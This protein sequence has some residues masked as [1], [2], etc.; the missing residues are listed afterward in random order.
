MPG[1]Q[2][3]SRSPERL[4]GSRC[5]G[6]RRHFPATSPAVVVAGVSTL[7][8]VVGIGSLVLLWATV[9]GPRAVISGLVH[10]P[11]DLG[12]L[13]GQRTDS[14]DVVA[15]LV[16]LGWL[17]WLWMSI[18]TA[19]EV[20]AHIRGVHPIRLPGSAWLQ[21]AAGLAVGAMMAAVPAIRVGTIV[22]RMPD[23]THATAPGGHLVSA[24]TGPRSLVSRA[25]LAPYTTMAP[26]VASDV[27][28]QAGAVRPGFPE[29]VVAAMS[30]PGHDVDTGVGIVNEAIYVVQPGDTM[31]SI[32]A[33]QLG[34]PL[35]W[36]QIAA[37]NQ[38]RVQPGGQR[39]LD[40]NWILPGW[41]L[42]M[43]PTGPVG[44]AA[45][46]ATVHSS[47]VDTAVPSL[48]L[49][50]PQ[51][52][53]KH[54][55]QDQ[56]SHWQMSEIHSVNN[57]SLS[58]DP[59]PNSA[60]P[61]TVNPL[62]L[63]PASDA[64]G[65]NRAHSEDN[66]SDT[67]VTGHRGVDIGEGIVFSVLSAG[68]VMLVNRLRRVQQ[69]H[70]PT[71]LRI[72]LPSA[73]AAAV[74]GRL[75]HRANPQL[76]RQAG[77]VVSLLHRAAGEWGRT[78]PAVAGI[79]IGPGG[80]EVAVEEV[81]SKHRTLTEV[82]GGSG[83]IPPFVPGS[84]PG[85]WMA[86]TGFG[87][88]SSST[89][90]L[91]GESGRKSESDTPMEAPS[92]VV[93]LGDDHGDLILVDLGVLSTLALDGPW[94]SGALRAMAVELA[95]TS[96]ADE[97]ELVLVG[98]GTAFD[99]FDRIRTIDDL[100]AACVLARQRV[101]EFTSLPDRAITGDQD[102]EPEPWA[103]T[104]FLCAGVNASQPEWVRANNGEMPFTWGSDR[105]TGLEIPGA[106]RQGKGAR[107]T[108]ISPASRLAEL[109]HKS[110]GA[111]AVV[112]E[113]TVPEA[114][115]QA[116][117]TGDRVVLRRTPDSSTT[118][119]GARSVVRD[120]AGIVE[121]HASGGVR[122]ADSGG[123]GVADADVGGPLAT[124]LAQQVDVHTVEQIGVL[125]D[126][127]T[128]LT[129]VDIDAA[130]YDSLS[131]AKP[132]SEP[133]GSDQVRLGSRATVPGGDTTVVL[134]VDQRMVQVNVLGPVEVVGNERPFTRAWSLDLVVYL[135]LHAAGATTDQWSTALWPDRLMAPASLHSTASAARRALGTDGRGGDHLPR[136]HGRLQLAATVSTDWQAF[137]A[138]AAAKDPD[139]WRQGL[140]LVRGRP[141][142]GLRVVDWAIL[143]GV[144][145]SIES[146]V[147]DLASRLA[148]YYL[149]QRDADGA[150]WAARQGLLV[151]PYDER[152]YRMLFR[153][154]DVGGNPAGV[155]SAMA[156]LI[157]LVAEDI[158]PYD[159]IHPETLTLYRALSRRG[160]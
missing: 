68:V 146:A 140:Q 97:V 44:A 149:D 42:L 141:F 127:A 78:V 113:G 128:K 60:Q 64:P 76:R 29:K 22:H 75:R 35:R 104:V 51:T 101:A 132:T 85:W 59:M 92:T 38:G 34:S 6:S 46:A 26:T 158:E 1:S 98:C 2:R 37:L 56:P 40:D 112:F 33:A 84:A 91:F 61:V 55:V 102:K 30:A 131:N 130:P 48:V 11:G 152:L 96:V 13:L 39:L 129:G 81:C 54:P 72:A 36:R 120:G 19:V 31:W 71:G 114:R 122:S 45:Q 67:H 119:Q 159:A 145:P 123:S 87:V 70:R 135:A 107:G 124:V 109:A 80:A 136:A 134:P 154:A 43:P 65:G 58:P 10:H 125:L 106:V 139:R 15:V 133:L 25:P 99:A 110:G 28:W 111:V 27:E 138:A 8:L 83:P 95:T 57:P 7:L 103:T 126:T 89:R 116:W 144:L 118:R 153:A 115:W 157:R 82:G 155:E 32:A 73:D 105:E 47:M 41:T 94:A 16:I 66:T 93:S 20:V 121:S 17:L 151:S 160:E 18:C 137:Q 117:G 14:T 86:P 69:R 148:A 5:S 4:D 90:A 12:V 142:D 62:R 79:R 88:G 3:S 9:H 49:P 74:E 108:E 63:K 21:K 53:K 100:D 156:E 52:I 23:P 77:I 143:E 150:N 147:V 50:R 24:G